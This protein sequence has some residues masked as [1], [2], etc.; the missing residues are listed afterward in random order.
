MIINIE[1]E[2]SEQLKI[3][4]EFDIIIQDVV[5]SVC[6][7]MK[8]PYETEVNVMFTDDE[9]IHQIN[10]EN[11]GIDR[12][13]DVLSFPLIEWEV[14]GFSVDRCFDRLLRMQETVERDGRISGTTHRYLIVAK[15]AC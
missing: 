1:N 14:P 10:K 7:F 4:K 3:L 2:Y 6:D 15:K 8:C 5:E 12:A 13:T 9:T 11:R